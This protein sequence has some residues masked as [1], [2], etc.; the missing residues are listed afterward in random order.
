MKLK[1]YD[2]VEVMSLA[3]TTAALGGRKWSVSDNGIIP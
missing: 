1:V 3:L 2:E